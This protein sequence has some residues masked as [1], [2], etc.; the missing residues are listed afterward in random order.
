M[1]PRVTRTG[2]SSTLVTDGL[3]GRAEGGSVIDQVEDL[4]SHLEQEEESQFQLSGRDKRLKSGQ[5]TMGVRCHAVVLCIGP[6]TC[7]SW[8]LIVRRLFMMNELHSIGVVGMSEPYLRP[9][10]QLLG[11]TC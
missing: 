8:V 3:L 6:M 2:N 4:Y 9:L 11:T 7:A 1:T 5:F 10:L